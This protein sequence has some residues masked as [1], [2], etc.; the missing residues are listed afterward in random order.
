MP[1]RLLLCQVYAVLVANELHMWSEQAVLLSRDC[2]SLRCYRINRSSSRCW[3]RCMNGQCVHA[4][5]CVVS[6]AEKCVCVVPMV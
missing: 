3:K 2:C 1:V 6:A 4:C 5:L